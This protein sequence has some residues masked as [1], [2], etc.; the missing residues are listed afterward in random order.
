MAKRVS[1][2]LLKMLEGDIVVTRVARH[3]SLGRVNA[4]HDRQTPIET[5]NFRPAAIE[6]ACAL[7][8]AEHQ[9]FL[10]ERA[11]P[12]GAC[13][14]INCREIPPRPHGAGRQ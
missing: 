4:D 11:G 12:G 13:V 2:R 1:T 6:R 9:V 7:A 10:D 14:P 8:G 5:E 3:Y